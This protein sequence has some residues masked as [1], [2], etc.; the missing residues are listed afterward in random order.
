[1][2]RRLFQT[3]ALCLLL[4]PI[5]LVAQV[6]TATMRQSP[7]STQGIG[8]DGELMET[9]NGKATLMVNTSSGEIKLVFDLNTF[10]TGYKDLDAMLASESDQLTFTGNLGMSLFNLTEAS[11]DGKT[12]TI[13][14]DVDFQGK[15]AQITAIF[16]PI[17]FSGGGF[18][19]GNDLRI[20]FKLNLDPKQFYITGFSDQGFSALTLEVA[21]G[22]INAPR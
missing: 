16:D 15:Q 20:N 21:P 6:S 8:P 10:T 2:L 3:I 17:T 14:G 7:V 18:D 1:M 4:A 9:K 11:N 12:Y 5:S 13:N 22:I 19:G